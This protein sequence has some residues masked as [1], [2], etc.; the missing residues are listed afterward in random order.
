M[1]NRRGVRINRGGMGI[2][3][4][5]GGRVENSLKRNKWGVGWKIHGRSIASV[6][7]RKFFYLSHQNRIQRSCN[8]LSCYHTFETNA[9]L[10]RSKVKQ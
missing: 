3:G 8:V 5:G 9:F 7:W 2:R 6:G 10:S 1:P 4:G